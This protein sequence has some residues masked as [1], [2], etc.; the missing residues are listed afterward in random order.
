LGGLWGWK[1]PQKL[2]AVRQWIVDFGGLRSGGGRY[3]GAS[4]RSLQHYGSRS[5]GY[6]M[7]RVGVLF[8]FA[9]FATNKK[10]PSISMLITLLIGDIRL[11]AKK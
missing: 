2:S 3:G 11:L 10:P 5:F 4:I 8:A 1:G 7:D 6:G 9:K